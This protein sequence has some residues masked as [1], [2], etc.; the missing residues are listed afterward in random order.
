MKGKLVN[1]VGARPQFVKVA[2]VSRALREA[3]LLE[4]SCKH[5]DTVLP[6][7]PPPEGTGP[8]STP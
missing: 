8:R 7:K 4:G 2:V 1:V 3:G 6:V 5:F